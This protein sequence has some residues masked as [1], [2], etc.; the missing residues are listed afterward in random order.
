MSSDN[1]LGKKR[2]LVVDDEQEVRD[3]IT[4]ILSDKYVVLAASTGQYALHILEKEKVDLVLLD[5]ALKDELDGLKVLRYL[6]NK[7]ETR[8]VPVCMLTCITSRSVQQDA[9][10]LGANEY[11]EK[12]FKIEYLIS[13]VNE[14]LIESA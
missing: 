1:Q 9:R 2:I 10:R 13:K 12:P 7:P 5:I 3:L 14:L 6:R 8:I 4:D 11:I